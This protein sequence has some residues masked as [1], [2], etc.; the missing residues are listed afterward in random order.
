MSISTSPRKLETSS[1][2]LI[3]P[4]CNVE[5]CSTTII[6]VPDPVF[7]HLIPE[8]PVPKKCSEL[9]EVVKVIVLFELEFSFV[10]I[11]SPCRPCTLLVKLRSISSSLLDSMYTPALIAEI[12]PEDLIVIFP[13][14]FRTSIPTE[15][16]N[17][18]ALSPRA[19]I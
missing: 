7:L 1:P 16:T 8:P 2:Y 14:V 9:N 19:N 11:S 15:F 10:T 12:A 4:S 13:L 5:E 18:P 6:V 17:V 3:P